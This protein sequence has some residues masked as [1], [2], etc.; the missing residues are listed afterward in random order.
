M[1]RNYGA[2]QASAES[3]V[4][5]KRGAASECCSAVARTG[6]KQRHLIFA[7]RRHKIVRIRLGHPSQLL[8]RHQLLSLEG[9]ERRVPASGCPRSS[10]WGS[11]RNLTRTLRTALLTL[12]PRHRQ[13]SPTG[14]GSGA[15]AGCRAGAAQA[16]RA[17][18]RASR[19]LR[20]AELSAHRVLGLASPC[21]VAAGPVT[22]WIRRARGCAAR[23]AADRFAGSQGEVSGGPRHFFFI[24]VK[25]WLVAVRED[26]AAAFQ[27][28][29]YLLSAGDVRVAQ[30]TL[31]RND[32]SS[33]HSG[34]LC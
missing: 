19:G 13:G 8:N 25:A 20:G 24:E 15:V 1:E 33:V 34:C 2:A 31:E 30:P 5:G 10:A 23:D 18:G 4:Q 6:P 16:V 7:E 9:S 22:A 3:I 21:E 29:L 27:R 32:G 12:L 17:H 28:S 26:D 11:A 14:R